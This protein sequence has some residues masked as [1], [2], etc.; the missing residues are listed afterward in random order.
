[1]E[2]GRWLGRWRYLSSSLTTWVPSPG[3]NQYLQIVLWFPHMLCGMHEPTHMHVYRYKHTHT[4]S[5]AN[6]IKYVYPIQS[7][8]PTWTSMTG[9]SSFPSSPKEPTLCPFCHLTSSRHR[10]C[11]LLH[12]VQLWLVFQGWDVIWFLLAL[13]RTSQDGLQVQSPPL[14]RTLRDLVWVSGQKL[15]SHGRHLFSGFK[16][17]PQSVSVWG[18]VGPV[19]SD[20][21]SHCLMCSHRLSVKA[22]L[23]QPHGQYFP[24]DDCRLKCGVFKQRDTKQEITSTAPNT[25]FL[26]RNSDPVLAEVTGWKTRWAQR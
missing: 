6:K 19:G 15:S 1:M 4:P 9:A 3:E 10:L 2:P 14:A 17:I 25:Y 21:K 24:V 13:G 12:A 23:R 7:V 18:E 11:Q 8:I 22:S 5:Q 16:L 20:Q 26:A